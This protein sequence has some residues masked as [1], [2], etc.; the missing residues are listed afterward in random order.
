MR[1]APLL[2]LAAAALAGCGSDRPAASSAA[3]S[4]D[5]STAAPPT[6]EDH[7]AVD[8]G[9]IWYR[10]VGRGGGTPVILLHGGP[11]F[12]SFYLKPLEALGDERVVVRY[13]QLGGGRSD[14]L[15]DSAR[16]T[17]EHF[18]QELDSL[19]S[20]LGYGRV[21][22]V[23]HSWGTILAVEYQRAHPEHVA[24]MVLGSA[25]LDIPAWER[26]ARTL[27]ATLPDSLQ[28][29][30]HAREQ[31]GRFDAP[32]YQAAIAEFYSR[33]VWL[34]PVAADLDSTMKTMNP[35]IYGY[36]QGPS[37]FTI[38][39]TLKNYNAVPGLSAIRVPLLYLVGDHDEANPELVRGFASHTPGARV[40]VIPNS[41]HMLTW[42]NPDA[43][44]SA[45]REFLRQA[46]ARR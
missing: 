9:R 34:R 35:A 44:V 7:L 6:R 26:N 41:A 40:E 8:G 32:D 19:R 12:S 3:G 24:S 22:L 39:G 28:R 30:V 29:V 31:E 20:H 23:G 36:M 46:E 2:L 14:A 17:I 15:T 37:E 38:T 33:Y 42:D 45:V 43:T 27:L 4:P 5:D 16:F 25:A 10:T 18:V 21:H 13:D 1:R 11:G